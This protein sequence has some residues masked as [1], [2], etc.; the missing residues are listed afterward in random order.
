MG[1][2]KC[3]QHLYSGF[4][5][6]DGS[7]SIHSTLLKPEGGADPQLIEKSQQALLNIPRKKR[8]VKKNPTTKQSLQFASPVICY[9]RRNENLD[10]K[11]HGKTS[12]N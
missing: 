4:L 1:S 6:D 10:A 7:S 5:H 11:I 2:C 9:S 8:R 3:Q 12:E